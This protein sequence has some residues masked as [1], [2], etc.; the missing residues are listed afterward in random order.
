MEL[1]DVV[2]RIF[3]RLDF[4]GSGELS[5]AKLSTC[6]RS[7]GDVKGANDLEKLSEDCSTIDLIRVTPEGLTAILYARHTRNFRQ[8]VAFSLVMWVMPIV[9]W[10]N[11]AIGLSPNT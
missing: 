11:L 8:N 10:I 2:N 3:S 1:S 4:D 6:L 7:L 5:L 9:E